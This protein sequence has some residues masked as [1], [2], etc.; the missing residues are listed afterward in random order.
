MLLNVAAEQPDH[1]LLLQRHF[2]AVLSSVW[3]MTSRADRQQN[4]SSRNGIYF[5][6]KFFNSFNQISWNSVKEPAKRMRFT[7]SAQSCKL[8]AAALHEFNSR[9]LDDA[10]SIS[11]R[12]EDPCFSEQLEVTLEFEKEEGDLSIPLPPI[13]NLTIPITDPQN[14]RIKDV[15][16]HNL[17]AVTNVAESRFRYGPLPP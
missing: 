3:R 10:V 6:G 15:G 4:L 11:N 14:F 12:I 5:G 1:E 7:T 9:P 13:I 8:L 16:E 2:T 17:K